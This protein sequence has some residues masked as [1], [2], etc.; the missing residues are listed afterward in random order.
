MTS[1]RNP[2]IC[3]DAKTKL[4]EEACKLKGLPYD[5]APDIK[6]AIKE[7]GNPLDGYDI[8]AF[9]DEDYFLND[10]DKEPLFRK[11]EFILLTHEEH[12]SLEA[13][14]HAADRD[15]ENDRAWEAARERALAEGPFF[16]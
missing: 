13:D 3:R 10:G 16:W 7:T 2:F 11:G 8:D 6:I 9:V 12:R 4:S 1:L 5:E 14:M 15:E